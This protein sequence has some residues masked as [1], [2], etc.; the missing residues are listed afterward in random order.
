MRSQRG[1]TLI[2][3]LVAVVV[4]GI[5]LTGMAGLQIISMRSG[6]Q[7]YQR[8]Q[9]TFLAYDVLDRMRANVPAARA[10]DYDTDFADDVTALP[11]CF[12]I[13][14]DC[15]TTEFA[16][17]DRRL[18]RQSLTASLPAGSG[19]VATALVAGQTQ[20]TITVQWV[21]TD[22]VDEAGVVTPQQFSLVARL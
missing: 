5:G 19:A 16:D 15:T 2:E 12:G 14:A 11:L 7:A 3:V 8:T 1:F 4:L 6:Q 13:G 17:H 10:G 22:S 20:V 18:W 21:D 9:A